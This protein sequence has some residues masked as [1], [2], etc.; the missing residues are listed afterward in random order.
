[1]MG[2]RKE[3]IF[4]DE[5]RA[6]SKPFERNKR[7]I[8][9]SS[10]KAKAKEVLLPQKQERG[11]RRLLSTRLPN[12]R[13]L[14]NRQLRLLRLLQSRVALEEARKPPQARHLRAPAAL[15]AGNDR[16]PKTMTMETMKITRS[17]R[18]LLLEAEERPLLSLLEQR[19]HRYGSILLH[20]PLVA[21]LLKVH[22]SPSARRCLLRYRRS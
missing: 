16:E 17:P 6:C 10:P 9:R 4:K 11:K 14:G 13:L 18:P 5:W 8:R 12:R 20:L 1:M 22:Y 19:S 21:N 15:P 7:S 3:L 2:Y